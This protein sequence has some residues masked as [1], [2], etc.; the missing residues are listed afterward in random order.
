MLAPLVP[1]VKPGGRPAL[2]DRSDIID[3]IFYV[4]RTGCS[5]RSLPTDFPHWMKVYSYF[6]EWKQSGVNTRLNEALRGEVR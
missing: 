3:A 4:N 2:H 5:W 1:A 6:R